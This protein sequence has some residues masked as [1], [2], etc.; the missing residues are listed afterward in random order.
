MGVRVRSPSCSWDADVWKP[1][2]PGPWT[3]VSHASACWWS[4]LAPSQALA[5]RAV[6]SPLTLQTVLLSKRDGESEAPERRR[7]KTRPL[8]AGGLHL[9]AAPTPPGARMPAWRRSARPALTAG[10]GEALP[11]SGRRAQHGLCR[12]G[13]RSDA[14][15]FPSL[16]PGPA[17]P[18]EGSKEDT[19]FQSR[20]APQAPSVCPPKCVRGQPATSS[21]P[22]APGLCKWRGRVPGEAVS[23]VGGVGDSWAHAGSREKGWRCVLSVTGEQ[24][25]LRPQIEVYISLYLYLHT[26]SA[27]SDALSWGGT[28]PHSPLLAP[29]SSPIRE[30]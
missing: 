3:C 20:A 23:S 12:Y 24:F 27:Q 7:K 16:P 19:T 15:P 18:Q 5:E 6:V 2:A 26:H 4:S 22:R 8:S 14:G 21:V 30:S 10:G 29:L 11:P 28:N 25:P 1:E 9:G 13:L 17:P